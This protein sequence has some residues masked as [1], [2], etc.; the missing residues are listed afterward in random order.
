[1]NRPNH[2]YGQPGHYGPAGSSP[3]DSL[4]VKDVADAE[5]ERVEIENSD[6]RRKCGAKNAKNALAYPD[7]RMTIC[8]AP[9]RAP[10]K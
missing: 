8:V 4:K 9:P 6:D 5:I 1:M 2:P 7:P 10:A 3:G